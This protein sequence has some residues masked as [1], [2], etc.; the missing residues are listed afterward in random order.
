MGDDDHLLHI[1]NLPRSDIW[2]RKVNGLLEGC[3]G[4]YQ[5]SPPKRSSKAMSR[6]ST[7]YDER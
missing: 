7:T 1:M 5:G 6:A 3:R 2:N 4:R